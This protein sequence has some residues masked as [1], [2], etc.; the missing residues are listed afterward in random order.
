[1]EALMEI[2]NK[3]KIPLLTNNQESYRFVCLFNWLD[4]K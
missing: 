2:N 3:D 4:K 1:M